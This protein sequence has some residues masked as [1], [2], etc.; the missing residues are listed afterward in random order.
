[1]RL[2]LLALTAGFL[3]A[4]PAAPV[5]ATTCAAPAYP[6]TDGSFHPEVTAKHLSCAKAAKVMLKHYK[7]RTETGPMGRCVHKVKGFACL[8]ER[9]SDFYAPDYQ[10]TVTCKHNRKKV[11]FG[12]NQTK[13]DA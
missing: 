5:Q 1:M 13:Y 3:L 6:A 9:Y 7:C 8:E 10:A 12:Y 2:L 11:V 4:L